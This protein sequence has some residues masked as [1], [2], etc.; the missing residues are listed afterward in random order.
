M[1]GCGGVCVCVCVCFIKHLEFQKK[2]RNLTGI[3]NEIVEKKVSGNPYIS[4]KTWL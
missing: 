2:T 1:W 4:K 3:P